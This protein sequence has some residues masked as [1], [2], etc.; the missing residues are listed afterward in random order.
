M[1]YKVSRTLLIFGSPSSNYFRHSPE[2]YHYIMRGTGAPDTWSYAPPNRSRESEN[3]RRQA[4]GRASL[5]RPTSVGSARLPTLG[6]PNPQNIQRAH[7]QSITQNTLN[8]IPATAPRRSITPGLTRQHS[9][10]TV[11][12]V[13]TPPRSRL[14]ET[15][16]SSSEEASP[17]VAVGSGIGAGDRNSPPR[18]RSYREY[19]NWS[20]PY[21]SYLTPNEHGHF[22]GRPQNSRVDTEHSGQSIVSE[23]RSPDLEY[24]QRHGE[25]NFAGTVHEALNDNR[26]SR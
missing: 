19:G 1:Q 2:E 9:T 6:P 20:D 17:P 15:S 4:R 3:R 23:G 24:P 14:S 16:S 22:A 21:A 12:T 13:V 18:T 8:S 5:G 26:W 7:L 10:G 11:P 25:F